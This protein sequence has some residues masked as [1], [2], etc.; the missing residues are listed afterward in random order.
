MVSFFNHIASILSERGLTCRAVYP[1]SSGISH[2]MEFQTSFEQGL[3]TKQ[4]NFEHLFAQFCYTLEEIKY[5]YSFHV[6]VCQSVHSLTVT[7]EYNFMTPNSPIFSGQNRKFEI[8]LL[9]IL[10]FHLCKV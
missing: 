9:Y 10:Y 3:T 5:L 2:T 8:S 7:I 6:T 1:L 4:V